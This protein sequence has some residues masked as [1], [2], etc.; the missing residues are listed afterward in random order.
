MLVLRLGDPAFTTALASGALPAFPAYPTYWDEITP[1]G[2]VART[3]ANHRDTSGGLSPCTLGVG[4]EE[5]LYDTDG[6]PS[7]S[8][9][10]LL[11]IAPCFTVPVGSP[12]RG[13]LDVA[14]TIAKLPSSGYATEVG[15][16]LAYNA[17]YASGGVR[18]AA[19][20]D[21][22]TFWLAGMGGLDWGFRAVTAGGGFSTSVSGNDPTGPGAFH[23]AHDGV[24]V[25]C[26]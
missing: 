10:G 2:A 12:M 15:L 3:T 9:D 5:W 16:V 13:A 23:G 6:L 7:N 8:A 19:T 11:A 20:V 21:G 18:Q 25:P 1:A 4:V 26:V 24:C 22:T 14:K 17:S